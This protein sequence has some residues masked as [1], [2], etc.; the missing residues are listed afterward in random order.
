MISKEALY[1]FIKETVKQ[2]LEEANGIAAGGVVGSA[3]SVLG[4]DTEP[5]K[6][7]MWSGDEKL[8]EGKV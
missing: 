5:G 7:M 6:K 4:V 2:E 8:R 3:G 1:Q